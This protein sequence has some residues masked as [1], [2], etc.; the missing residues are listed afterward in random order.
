MG[1]GEDGFDVPVVDAGGFVSLTPELRFIAEFR[2]IVFA[3]RGTEGRIRW[4]P[5]LSEGFQAS[6]RLQIS[7]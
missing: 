6:A 3:F 1:L 4:A 7:L 5:F 2:D